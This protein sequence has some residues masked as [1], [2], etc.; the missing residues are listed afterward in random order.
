MVSNWVERRAAKE[1]HLRNAIDL[2]NKVQATIAEV[3]HSL[4]THFADVATVRRGGQGNA[5]TIAIARASPSLETGE[6]FTTTLVSI[7]FKRDEPAITVS[8]DDMLT[9]EFPIDA[10]SDHAF[11]TLRGHEL[12]LDEFSRLALEEVFFNPPTP[13][14]SHQLDPDKALEMAR[15]LIRKLDAA[16]DMNMER[17]AV[18]QS[19]Q[20]EI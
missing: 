15:E 7:E 9:Q 20:K 6:I 10:D 3:C 1:R 13:Q 4:Q 11:I 2:W 12:L 17:A 5:L 19:I 18:T 8:V 16:S 14:P